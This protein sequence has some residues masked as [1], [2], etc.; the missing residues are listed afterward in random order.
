MNFFGVIVILI[1]GKGLKSTLEMV[2]GE[3][4]VVHMVNCKAV[5]FS[6]YLSSSTTCEMYYRLQ[7]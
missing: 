4:G 7:L 3:N 5:A 1:D 2:Y 6:G